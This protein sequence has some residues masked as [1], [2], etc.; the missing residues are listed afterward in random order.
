MEPNV[1]YLLVADSLL[2]LHVLFVAFVVIGLILILAG[3]LL[4]WRW[5]RNRHF[6]LAHLLAIGIVVIQSWLGI[7]CPLTTWE[8]ALREKA[9]DAVYSGTFV[10]HWL[11]S[12]LYFSA[13][14]WVFVVCYTIFGLL[15]VASWAWVRPEPPGREKSDLPPN[16]T[17]GP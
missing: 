13:P 9:G 8:M 12:I 4:A 11:E 15:V 16:A 10:S 2:F 5:V 17:K 3:G 7:V 14:P 1:I 6:R